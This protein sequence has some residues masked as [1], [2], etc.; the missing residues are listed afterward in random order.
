MT[1][2]SRGDA[3]YG[4]EHGHCRLQQHFDP[5]Q[6]R[7]ELVRSSVDGEGGRGEILEARRE[8]ERGATAWNNG[9]GPSLFDNETAR[10]ADSWTEQGDDV[11]KKMGTRSETTSFEV[12]QRHRE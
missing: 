5:R 9:R 6:W 10:N 3:Y 7:G 8:G 11:S 1:R 2:Y 4:Q 12:R